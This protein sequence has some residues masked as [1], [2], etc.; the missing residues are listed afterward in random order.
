M[1]TEI[2]CSTECLAC[3]R[4]SKMA[5]AITIMPIIII[6]IGVLN[7]LESRSEPFLT[8]VLILYILNVGILEGEAIKASFS[9]PFDPSGGSVFSFSS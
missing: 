1:H 3:P 6:I 8:A 2:R 7:V 4:Y 9:H 5:V